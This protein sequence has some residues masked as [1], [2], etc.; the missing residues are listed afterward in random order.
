MRR[1]G[2]WVDSH[3][4]VINKVPPQVPLGEEEPPAPLCSGYTVPAGPLLGSEGTAPGAHLYPGG[5]KE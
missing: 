3:L 1:P 2:S 5:P 4:K